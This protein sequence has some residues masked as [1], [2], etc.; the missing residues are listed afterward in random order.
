MR[1]RSS[2]MAGKNLFFGQVRYDTHQRT[3]HKND[4]PG[5]SVFLLM[6]WRY[7][8]PVPD[9][10]PNKREEERAIICVRGKEM[11]FSRISLIAVMLVV[12]AVALAGCSGSSPAT[13]SG[14]GTQAVGTTSSAASATPATG[15]VVSGANIFGTGATYN[16]IEYKTTMQGMTTLMR[17]EKSGKCTIT[18]KGQNV[19]GGSMTIDC[20]AKGGQTA[21]SQAQSNPADVKSDVKFTFVGIEPVTVPAGTYPAASKYSV[22]T[23]GNTMYYWTA[24]GVPTFVKYQVTTSN[25][26]I[27]TELNSWG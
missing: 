27:I 2:F 26:D 9:S 13:P 1:H 23:D 25:G 19:P 6:T 17:M 22:T 3:K 18:T 7:N 10:F 21:T 4:L 15:S 16:W 11:K 12:I 8:H 20:S 5:V 24:P 14:G